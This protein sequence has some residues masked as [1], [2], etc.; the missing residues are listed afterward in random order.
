MRDEERS[1]RM[2]L[3]QRLVLENKF[4]RKRQAEKELL[5]NIEQLTGNGIVSAAEQK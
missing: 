1:H 2:M 5:R 3:E 4:E